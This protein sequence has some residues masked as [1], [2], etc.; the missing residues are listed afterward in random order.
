MKIKPILLLRTPGPIFQDSNG[1]RIESTAGA[2]L[3]LAAAGTKHSGKQNFSRWKIVNVFN[4]FS[5]FIK[6]IYPPVLVP[7]ARPAIFL[8]ECLHHLT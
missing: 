5:Y 6:F 8:F 1:D 7:A 3:V 4:W 2:G